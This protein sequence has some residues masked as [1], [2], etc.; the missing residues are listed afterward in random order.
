MS[1]E[2]KDKKKTVVSTTTG[3]KAKSVVAARLKSDRN[4][5]TYN[6]D[7]MTFGPETFKW[8]GIGLGLMALGYI[9]MLGGHN[10]DPNVWDE[11]V[12]YNWRILIVA[13][14]FILA[15]LGVQIFAIF[16]K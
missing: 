7:E 11:S 10:E 14:L 4:A 16:K 5:G 12:I 2:K 8:M 3:S 1:K 6:A 9:L 15:G 13:P